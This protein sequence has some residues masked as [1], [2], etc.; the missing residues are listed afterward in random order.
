MVESF[1]VTKLLSPQ[2]DQEAV[3]VFSGDRQGFKLTQKNQHCRHIHDS[4][5]LPR[6]NQQTYNDWDLCYVFPSTVKKANDIMTV[7]EIKDTLLELCRARVGRNVEELNRLERLHPVYGLDVMK[8]SSCTRGEFAELLRSVFFRVLDHVQAYHTEEIGMD[9]NR[10]LFVRARLSETGAQVIADYKDYPLCVDRDCTRFREFK[11]DPDFMPPYMKFERQIE[12]R[13][14]AVVWQRYDRLSRRLKGVPLHDPEASIFRDV[15]RIRLLR[16]AVFEFLNVDL[17]IRQKWLKACYAVKQPAVEKALAKNWASFRHIWTLDQ[18]LDEVRNY[19]G[20]ETALYYGWLAYYTRCLTVPALLGMLTWLFSFLTRSE[21]HQDST[22]VHVV[23]F[24][25][26]VTIAIWST[27]FFNLWRRRENLLA[28]RWGTEVDQLSRVGNEEFAFF[29][30][31][32]FVQDPVEPDRFIRWFS[33][34]KRRFRMTLTFIF[35]IV[36]SA[37]VIFLVNDDINDAIAKLFGATEYRGLEE[38]IA[39]YIPD[40]KVAA[41]VA[42]VTT[43]CIKIYDRLWTSI[44]SWRLGEFE[45]HQYLA[46]YNN[47]TSFKVFVFR[48]SNYFGVIIYLAFFK[49]MFNPEDEGETKDTSL[50]LGKQLWTFFLLDIVLNLVEIGSPLF[51]YYLNKYMSKADPGMPGYQ[52]QSYLP[53]YKGLTADYMDKMI[54]F[55]YTALFSVGVPFLPLLGMLV[56]IIEIRSDAFKMLHMYRRPFPRFAESTGIWDDLQRGMTF[57]GIISNVLLCCFVTIGSE[58]SLVTKLSLSLLLSLGALALKDFVEFRLPAESSKYR[59][60]KARMQVVDYEALWGP[61]Q[62]TSTPDKL[63]RP[64]IYVL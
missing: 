49:N 50:T 51:T 5:I 44:I 26:S 20:E 30:P 17:M 23:A 6:L 55:G 24:M 10:D 1:S 31:E 18:P 16:L 35:L 13:N 8:L 27:V 48:V 37:L 36:S 53:A 52:L 11:S 25:F 47:S 29:K 59:L 33:P 22:W 14:N 61:T 39:A 38:L 64:Q 2:V 3:A 42:V 54:E 41:Q 4:D 15:D 45:N 32:K 7:Q 43:L 28:L 40:T 9:K 46:D 57:L 62:S 60:L 34:T 19:F 58:H 63:V 12:E 56:N 21:T